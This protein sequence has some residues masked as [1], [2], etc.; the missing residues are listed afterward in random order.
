M[1]WGIEFLYPASMRV[2]L[3]PAFLL[4]VG[5][6]ASADVGPADLR[7]EVVAPGLGAK[8]DDYM[9]RLSSFDYSGSVLVEYKGE[10]ILNKGYGFANRE[11]HIPIRPD[12]L[13]EIGSF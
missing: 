2:R 12:T 13:F 1:C 5:C 9:R 8:L 7:K 11:K 6:F 4:L 10:I 3:L